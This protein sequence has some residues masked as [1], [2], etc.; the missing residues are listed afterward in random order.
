MGTIFFNFFRKGEG[1]GGGGQQFRV[2]EKLFHRKLFQKQIGLVK[3]EK[4]FPKK[5]FL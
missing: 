5:K 3:F 1:G 4:N 2:F